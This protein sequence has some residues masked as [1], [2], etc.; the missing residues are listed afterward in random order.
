[1]TQSMWQRISTYN[2]WTSFWEFSGLL[3]HSNS[4]QCHQNWSG[5]EK[6]LSQRA[7][8]LP[9]FIAHNFGTSH[10]SCD[11]T[12]TYRSLIVERAF[13][14]FYFCLKLLTRFQSALTSTRLFL[15]KMTKFLFRATK[16]CLTKHFSCLLPLSS[17]PCV[18]TVS[19]SYHRT[20]IMDCNCHE[21]RV[22]V[23]I[24]RTPLV[25]SSPEQNV[26]FKHAQVS[27]RDSDQS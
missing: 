5:G 1:M 3:Q 26:A 11:A 18:Q 27:L 7:Y 24:S 14:F 15:L 12:S 13:N 8:S 2:W 21:K 9:F 16:Y 6:S 22:V 10:K 25:Y 19:S 23:R 17:L 4:P 20:A